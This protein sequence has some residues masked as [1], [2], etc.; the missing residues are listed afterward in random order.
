ML[1]FAQLEF[2]CDYFRNMSEYG[3]AL[4]GIP[5]VFFSGIL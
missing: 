5:T 4:S 2:F 3:E 1:K